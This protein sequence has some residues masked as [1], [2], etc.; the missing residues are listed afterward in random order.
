MIDAKKRQIT[1]CLIFIFVSCLYVLP[2]ILNGRYFIDDLGRSLGGYTSWGDDGRPLASSLM[3]FINMGTPLLDLSPLPQLMGIA[4]LCAAL[5]YFAKKYFKFECSISVSL[6]LFLFLSNPFLI[7]NL[8]YK[9]DGFFMLLSLTVIILPFLFDWE[10][11]KKLDFVVSTICVMVSLCFYQ[12]SL[13]LFLILIVIDVV[14]QVLRFNFCIKEKVYFCLIKLFSLCL[15][16]LLYKKFVAEKMVTSGY[17]K[18]HSEIVSFDADGYHIVINN[19]EKANGFLISYAD[20]IPKTIIIFYAIVFICAMVIAIKKIITNYKGLSRL[21]SITIVI[22]APFLSFILSVIH[23]CLINSPVLAPRVFTSFCG[24][25]LYMGVFLLLL[26][27]RKKY[28]FLLFLPIIQ[29]SFLYSFSYFNVA[30]AQSR[31]DSLVFS[32]LAYDITH[33][34]SSSKRLSVLGKMPIAKQLA[35]TSSRIPLIKN[36][37]PVYLNNDWSW[38]AVALRHYNM[39]LDMENSTIDEASHL[40]QLKPFVDSMWYQLFDY[41]GKIFILFDMQKCSVHD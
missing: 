13:G 28:M 31:M 37:V 8:S 12:S 20:S 40:C 17:A 7:E 24:V 39:N 10:K 21:F 25:L 23:I 14:C 35:L 18:G 32:S 33:H 30:S 15:G 11:N 1:L 16:F 6:V 34:N 27:G 26:W 9:Y 22:L 4:S 2:I 38:G 36:L 41:N 19:L 29:I 5:L 3:R